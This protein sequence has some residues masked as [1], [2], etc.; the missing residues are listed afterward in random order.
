M[1]IRLVKTLRLDYL[2]ITTSYK[3]DNIF[4]FV[5]LPNNLDPEEYLIKK[6]KDSF[7]NLL[8]K[9]YSLSELFGCWD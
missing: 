1:V 5:F 3:T 7:N 6:G 8:K 2:K 9:S 4:R